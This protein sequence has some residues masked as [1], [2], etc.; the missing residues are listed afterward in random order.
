M[1]RAQPLQEDLKTFARFNTFARHH[2]YRHGFFI[3]NGKYT[4]AIIES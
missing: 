2:F 4:G 3:V 1:I